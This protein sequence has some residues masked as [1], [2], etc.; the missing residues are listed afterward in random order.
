MSAEEV[1]RGACPDELLINDGKWTVKAAKPN[2]ANPGFIIKGP[3]GRYWLLKMDGH[4]DP[5]RAT[6]ADVIGSRLYHAAGFHAPCNIVVY[7]TPEIFEIDPGSLLPGM[8]VSRAGD[9]ALVLL[10]RTKSVTEGIVDLE[11]IFVG[12][13]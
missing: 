10:A 6:S 9:D 7:F 4:E 8:A 2:G 3:K 13:E 1:A 5:E 12:L 11:G